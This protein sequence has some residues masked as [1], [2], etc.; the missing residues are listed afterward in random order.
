ML[1]L[2]SAEILSIAERVIPGA[3]VRDAGLIEAAAARPQAT[4]DGRYAY[5]DVAH[6]AA[7]F[8]QSLVCNHGLVDGNKRL[9]LACLIVFMRMNGHRLRMSNDEAYDLIYGLASGTLR[10]VEDVARVLAGML[11]P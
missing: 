7:A 1:F 9:G 4:L 5:P 6:M 11:E 3:T 2:T 8:T 10:S